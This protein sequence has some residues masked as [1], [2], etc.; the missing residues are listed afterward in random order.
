MRGVPR[1]KGGQR[2]RR[3]AR[4]GAFAGVGGQLNVLFGGDGFDVQREEDDAGECGFK[5]EMG[6]AERDVLP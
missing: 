4:Q 6:N 5:Q 1:E 3:G 2:A